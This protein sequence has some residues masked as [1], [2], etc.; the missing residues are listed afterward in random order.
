M[1]KTS[2][3][4]FF[5]PEFDSL[6]YQPT[7]QYELDCRNTNVNSNILGFNTRYAEYKTA[8]DEVHGEFRHS[9]SL[10]TWSSPR[11]VDYSL[12]SG[13]NAHFLTIDPSVLNPIFAVQYNGHQNT[14]QF[15]VN[16]FLMYL[17]FVLCLVS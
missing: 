15:M 17:L 8:V 5:V 7:F 11:V 10:N 1:T 6:G 12:N 9:G 2:R 4:Q 14:D 3:E 16:S 13:L